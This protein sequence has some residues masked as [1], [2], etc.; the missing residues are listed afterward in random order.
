MCVH[1]P[2]RNV[3]DDVPVLPECLPYPFKK[4]SLSGILSRVTQNHP[5]LR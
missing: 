2:H 4:L 5:A 3:S 1:L